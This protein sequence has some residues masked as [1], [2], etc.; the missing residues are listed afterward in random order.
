MQ[1]QTA[2]QDGQVNFI[3]FI[4]YIAQ[5][6]NSN[7]LNQLLTFLRNKSALQSFIKT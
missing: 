4:F 7:R 2:S 6:Y 5:G 3:N 1:K